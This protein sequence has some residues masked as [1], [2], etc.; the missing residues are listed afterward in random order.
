MRSRTDG[1]RRRMS[2]LPTLAGAAW[3]IA[4]LPACGGGLKYTVD[5]RALDP[6][7]INER[8]SVASAHQDEQNAAAEQRAAEALLAGLARDTDQARKEKEQAQLETEK[9]VAEQEGAKVAH[10]ENQANAAAHNK[11]VAD[12]G[13]KVAEAH[14]DW[15]DGKRDWCKQSRRTADAHLM[16]AQAKVELE[17]ARVAQ[18]KGIQ[19]SPGFQLSD[20]EAQWRDQD[21]KWQ[22]EKKDAAA[23]EKH[24]K[25]RE[26]AWKDLSAQ[27]RKLRGS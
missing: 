18:R 7:P 15:L 5:D 4:S 19:P 14:L 6:V 23:D 27:L 21:A 20:Y 25:K 17:K 13:V 12:L 9:A 10:D 1:A 8:A 16:A 11:D 26:D 24:A 2:L 22:S 3:A